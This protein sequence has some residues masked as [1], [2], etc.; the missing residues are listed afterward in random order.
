MEH[1]RIRLI[2]CGNGVKLVLLLLIQLNFNK[3]ITN[4]EMLTAT[5]KVFL[6]NDFAKLN[7]CLRK[8]GFFKE[9]PC[10][11]EYFLANK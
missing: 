10:K 11:Y 1:L 5:F 6:L 7:S 3:F 2:G 8:N 4:I 9:I